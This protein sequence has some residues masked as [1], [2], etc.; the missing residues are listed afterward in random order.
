MTSRRPKTVVVICRIVWPAPPWAATS[1][2]GKRCVACSAELAR[3]T[4]AAAVLEVPVAKISLAAG[5]CTRCAAR[6]D[7]DLIAAAYATL[8]ALAPSLRVGP[9]GSA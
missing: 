7:R 4:P 6:H 2:T 9:G 1:G 5:I 8:R 3:V